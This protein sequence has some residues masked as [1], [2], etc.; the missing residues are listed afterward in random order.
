MTHNVTMKPK[1]KPETTTNTGIVPLQNQTIARSLPQLGGQFQGD[2]DANDKGIPYLSLVQKQGEYAQKDS[3]S[4]GKFVYDKDV[5]LGSEIRVIFG[6]VTKFFVEKLTQGSP[7]VPQRF[8]TKKEADEAIEE[9]RKMRSLAE[10]QGLKNIPELMEVTE[11]ANIDL[12]VEVDK[13]SE[14]IKYANKILGNK[15]YILT[16]YTARSTAYGTT[17]KILLKDYFSFLKGD[18]S[19]YYYKMS[20]VEKS[21]QGFNW[22]APTLRVD[23]Q[24]SQE[25]KEVAYEIFGVK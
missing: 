4:L 22:F 6:L 23:G 19:S 12:L 16:R 18:L 15:G 3:S 11:A 2:Y 10:Q 14:L 9:S 17:V 1:N 20:S 25:V 21:N 5:L 13:D 24:V 7:K 8:D